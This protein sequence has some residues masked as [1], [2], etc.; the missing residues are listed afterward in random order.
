MKSFRAA[1]TSS[2]V[3]VG[4]AV[5][6]VA[7]SSSDTPDTTTAVTSAVELPEASF[8]QALHDSLPSEIKDSGT[9]R[10]AGFQFPPYA[11]YS[12]DGKTL[13]GMYVEVAQ[14]LEKVLG[15]K[16]DFN[17]EPSIG[18]VTTALKSGRADASLSSLADLPTT[19]E[20]FDFADWIREYVIFMVKKGNPKNITDIDSTCG[21]S[22]AT[23]QGGPSEKVLQTK[24][25]ECTKDGKEPIN[26]LTF[27][28]QNTAVLAV[29]SGRA[30]AAFSQQIPLT[31]YVSQDSNFELAGVNQAN[32]FPNL[33]FGAYALK[34]RPIVD[35]LLGAFESLRTDG[36]YDAWLTKYGIE[37]NNLDDFGINLATQSR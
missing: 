11:Y 12:E 6:L 23:L 29:R 15:V 24:T 14:S 1:L 35:V 16:I 25:E 30:D 26:I 18:D 31:Y 33:Y 8:N 4:L 21:T 9:L 28:D 17:V 22:I 27:A 36:L 13:Q 20:T 10:L 3:A 32:G 7:C 2:A 34:D 5:S 19:E 37:S